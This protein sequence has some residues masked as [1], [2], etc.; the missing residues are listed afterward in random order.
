MLQKYWQVNLKNKPL[1]KAEVNKGR[2]QKTPLS[3][4]IGA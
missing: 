2:Y 4:L 3:T 1:T